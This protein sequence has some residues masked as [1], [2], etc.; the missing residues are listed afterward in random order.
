[1]QNVKS[2]ALCS[3]RV[4]CDDANVESICGTNINVNEHKDYQ[5]ETSNSSVIS[6]DSESFSDISGARDSSSISSSNLKDEDAT[7]YQRSNLTDAFY[8]I[9]SEN[10]TEDSS[11]SMGTGLILFRLIIIIKIIINA[12]RLTL[13]CKLVCKLNI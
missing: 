6:A 7:T 8:R 9:R 12:R 11:N 1:V 3:V 10:T 2:H 4:R 5:Y 13:T